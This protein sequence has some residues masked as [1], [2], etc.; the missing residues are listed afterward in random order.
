[1]VKCLSTLMVL[2][3]IYCRVYGQVNDIYIPRD[4]RSA[5][6]QGTRSYDGNPGAHYFQ[7]RADYKIKAEV[8]PVSHVLTGYEK[9]T[10]YNNSPFNLKEIG[11][12][13]YQNIFVKGGNRGRTVNQ[14]DLTDG[15]QLTSLTLNGRVVNLENNPPVIYESQTNTFFRMMAKSGTINTIEATWKLTFPHEKEERMGG[16]D[17]TS[18]FIS[19][20]FPQVAVYDDI[21][22]WD[23]FD[24]N[25]V[26]EMYN[27]YGNY[28]VTITVPQQFVVWAG[29][30]LQN[31]EEVLSEGCL[32]RYMTAKNGKRIVQ[33][34]TKKDIRKKEVTQ[35]GKQD[36]KFKASDVSDFAF[37]ISDH[38]LWDAIKMDAGNN[39]SVFVQSAYLASSPY[40]GQVAEMSAYV[41]SQLRDSVIRV[42]FPYP[43]M[44]VFYG[45]DGME[46]P[47]IV[48]DEDQ[49]SEAR[50]WFL[51]AH[52]ISHTY[53]PFL[54][55]INQRR[56]GWMD[57]G[58]TTV[59][60]QDIHSRKTSLYDLRQMYLY[61]YPQIAG[62]Q[63]DVPQIVNSSY[64]SNIIFQQHEYMR[65]SMAFWTLRDIL[66]KETFMKCLGG[67]IERWAGKHPT[68]Y[69][70][71]FTFND[72]SGENLN[73]F[74]QPWFLDFDYPDL[75]ISSVDN[76]GSENRILLENKGGMP[77]PSNLEVRFTDGTSRNIFIDARVWQQN[78]M[79]IV[80]VAKN[81]N[82]SGLVLHTEGYPDCDA[83][84]NKY[85][86]PRE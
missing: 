12:R 19:Y 84:N 56:Y 34:I 78:K 82:I 6:E 48:N 18:F 71:F 38:Y 52:E 79:H 24:Y 20:W 73:W 3:T 13:F 27:E 21:D 58:M 59:F 8:D 62:T 35:E 80:S 9:I 53:L 76:S 42:P 60:G 57:E 55:G 33:I 37:G 30:E 44:T 46:F 67:F 50:T 86:P 40:Y 74:W 85:P 36:W 25:N 31:P 66:G 47:M 41:I 43:S 69:D 28:D 5:Y 45:N 65:P 49:E 51:T 39:Q 14:S 7:N 4:I 83:G 1:M 61:M 68:P 64:L 29:G 77:F 17:E 26:A 70:M 32:T 11:L 16:I 10:F 2:L 75:G 81:K 72:I 54:V 15:V 22:G 63:E 23:T